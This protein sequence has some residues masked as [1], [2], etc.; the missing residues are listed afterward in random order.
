MEKTQDEIDRGI[1]LLVTN[2][3]DMVDMFGHA[4]VVVVRRAIWERH[5]NA[6]EWAVL[7]IDDSELV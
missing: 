2:W 3:S 7:V 6:T 5:G 1:A 4:I